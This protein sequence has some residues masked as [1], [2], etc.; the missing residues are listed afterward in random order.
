[1]R[2]QAR[3]RKLLRSLLRPHLWKCMLALAIVIGQNGAALV[4]PYLIAVAIDDG[5][6]HALNGNTSTLAW[7][8]GGYVVSALANSGLLMTFQRL[9]TRIGQDVVLDLR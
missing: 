5:I 3:S 6:P 8:V 2:L 9:S 1:M 4:G 7:C